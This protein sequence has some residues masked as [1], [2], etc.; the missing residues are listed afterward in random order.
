METIRPLN[1]LNM[2]GVKR[3]KVYRKSDR[4]WLEP[5]ARFFTMDEAKA[6]VAT[7]DFEAVIVL[8]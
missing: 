5:L 7:L 4:L 6:Y 2:T 3:Y 8:D 1:H